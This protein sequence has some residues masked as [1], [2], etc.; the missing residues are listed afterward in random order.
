MDED[1]QTIPKFAKRRM[2]TKVPPA[3]S[4]AAAAS[5]APPK[6][7]QQRGGRFCDNPPGFNARTHPIKKIALFHYI[8]RSRED[9]AIKRTRGGGTTRVRTWE[10]FE[11]F[12][13]CAPA[14]TCSCAAAWRAWRPDPP[15]APFH[16]ISCHTSSMR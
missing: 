7:R 15:S 5:G 9:F 4:S 2:C 10:E 14:S 11:E 12:D 6:I 1:E 3:V 16:T 8:T 13:K